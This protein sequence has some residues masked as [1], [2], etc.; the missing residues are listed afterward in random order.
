MAHAGGVE[1]GKELKTPLTEEQIKELYIKAGDELFHKWKSG[2]STIFQVEF[3][4]AIERAH[5]ITE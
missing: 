1:V 5:G 3:A 2:E 4:R